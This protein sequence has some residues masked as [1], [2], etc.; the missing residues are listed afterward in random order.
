MADGRIVLMQQALHL[1][2]FE[3]AY[4]STDTLKS[5]QGVYVIW[6]EDKGKWTVLDVGETTDVKQRV[7]NHERANS[8]RQNCTG[9]IYYSATYTLNLQQAE[10]MKIEKK[11]RDKANL[12]CGER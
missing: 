1:Y 3:G 7:G 11:I 12:L 2:Q 9:T 8:W 5:R 10:R 4:K 6:C